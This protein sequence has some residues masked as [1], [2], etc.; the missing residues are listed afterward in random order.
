MAGLLVVMSLV[1]MAGNAFMDPFGLLHD[2]VIHGVNHFKTRTEG[3]FNRMAKAHQI[4][5]YRPDVLLLGT[6][7]VDWAM[8]PNHPALQALSTNVFN[9]G[10]AGATIYEVYR[11][12]QHAHAIHPLQQVVIGL[13]VEMF[14]SC[15]I[16]FLCRI[17]DDLCSV[18]RDFEVREAG[19]PKQVTLIRPIKLGPDRAIVELIKVKRRQFER[20][21]R[22]FRHCCVTNHS[23][24]IHARVRCTNANVACSDGNKFGCSR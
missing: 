5:R 7:R 2:R 10:L 22:A 21:L 1:L 23:L 14:D 3:G 9:A 12:L 20:L 17:G 13:D 11:Y 6:S 15:L 4:R 18:R 19:K 24:V 8:D 16:T